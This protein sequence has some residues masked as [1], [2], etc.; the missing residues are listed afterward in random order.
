[1]KN[2][3]VLFSTLLLISIPT[4][5]S[6]YRTEETTE[7]K[8]LITVKPGM[9]GITSLLETCPAIADIIDEL[10]HELLVTR[11]TPSFDRGSRELV[12]SL[13]SSLNRCTFCTNCHSQAAAL[14]IGDAELVEAVKKDFTT[15]DISP[16]MKALLA[17]AV[18]VHNFEDGTAEAE[19]ARK[20]GANDIEIHDTALIVGAFNMFNRYV[21]GLNSFTP[22]EPEAYKAIGKRLAEKGY[23]A[24]KKSETS[25]AV[26]PETTQTGE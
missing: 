24:A 11:A 23:I 20:L 7:R 3:N 8:P 25:V 12:A 5:I 21:D 4:I 6:A 18:K 26:A 16:K 9:S 15:A 19:E 1:M 2:K 17:Y 14:L 10:T 22:T 13:I